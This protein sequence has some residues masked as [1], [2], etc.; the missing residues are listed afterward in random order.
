[1]NGGRICITR[2][3]LF[4]A[5]S[6]N[7]PASHGVQTSSDPNSSVTLS[8][9]HGSFP[10]ILEIET[11]ELYTP[12]QLRAARLEALEMLRVPFA[13]D[14]RKLE[15]LVESHR[16]VTNDGRQRVSKVSQFSCQANGASGVSRIMCDVAMSFASTAWKEGEYGWCYPLTPSADQVIAPWELQYHLEDGAGWFESSVIRD[17]LDAVHNNCSPW[18]SPLPSRK[19]LW[20]SVGKVPDKKVAYILEQAKLSGV[21][22]EEVSQSGVK[23]KHDQMEEQQTEE[24]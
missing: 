3:K 12:D 9:S 21:R 11:Y 10:P 15:D 5:L 20:E 6:K 22:R 8:V 18:K 19:E 7:S 23:R 13:E 14:M 24:V 17:G 1:M 2:K 4:I 16:Q